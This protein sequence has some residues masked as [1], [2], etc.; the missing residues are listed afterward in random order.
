MTGEA[1]TTQQLHDSVTKVKMS[2]RKKKTKRLAQGCLTNGHHSSN[3]EE[4]EGNGVF[5]DISEVIYE[6][7]IVGLWCEKMKYIYTFKLVNYHH[8]AFVNLTFQVLAFH[9]NKVIRETMSV[10]GM[11]H[12][13][14]CPCTVIL[15]LCLCTGR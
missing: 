7:K 3:H 13:F 8:S 1:K 10:C 15:K 11:W 12:T 6:W 2:S 9:L 14:I 5:K 4:L